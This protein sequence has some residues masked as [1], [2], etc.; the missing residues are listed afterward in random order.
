MNKNKFQDTVVDTVQ[1]MNNKFPDAKKTIF[2][3]L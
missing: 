1:H 2:S 3:A